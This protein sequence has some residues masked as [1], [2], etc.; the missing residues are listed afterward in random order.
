MSKKIYNAYKEQFLNRSAKIPYPIYKKIL[1][2]EFN[3]EEQPKSHSGGSKRTFTIG[4]NIV[5]VIHEPH[6]KGDPVGKWDH[7][8]IL[9][10]LKING[11]I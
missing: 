9:D 11:K 8:N 10:Q 6:K 5:F 7:H 3:A 1:I 2:E 4:D